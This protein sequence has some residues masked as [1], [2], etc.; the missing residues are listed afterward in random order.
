[1]ARP[2]LDIVI[3]VFNE[4]T[5]L[6]TSVRRLHQYLCVEFPYAWRITIADNASTDTTPAI[7]TRLAR[8]FS[9]VHS[10]RLEGKGRG[11]ALRE[12][13]LRSEAQVVAYMDVD[14]ST[15]LD[16]LM[17]LVAPLVSGDADVAIG[18]RL[19]HGARVTRGPK[20]EVISRVYNGVLRATMRAQFSDAQCGFKAAR[21]DIA[22]LLVPLVED[23]EWFFDTELLLLA[24]HNDL[25]I[26]EVPVEWVDDPDSRVDV[27]DTV[28]KDLLGLWRMK[29]RFLRGEGLL[30]PATTVSRAPSDALADAT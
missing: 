19:I 6:D 15:G 3:P 22:R 13:W 30:W 4:E 7:A 27:V 21:R 12:T 20:R 1:M 23:N 17:P 11:R 18:S 25:R 14:L 29:G 26:Q 28:R 10:V 5:D 8:D 24:Q 2:V 16:A 9:A